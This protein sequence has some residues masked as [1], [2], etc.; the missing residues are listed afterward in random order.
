N[1]SFP[2]AF[3]SSV[4]IA[5]SATAISLVVGSLAAW[6]LTRNAF[7]AVPWIEAFLLSPLLLARIIYGVAMLIVLSQLG[8]IR[9][10]LGL[11]LA[12]A[13]IVIPY[14]VRIVGST[15]VGIESSLEEA[16]AV[17]GAN[18]I[19]TFLKVTLPLLTPGIVAATVFGFI[20]SFDEF[21]MSVFL[22]GPRTKTLPVEMFKYAELVV[23]PSVAAASVMLILGTLI[24][25]FVLERTAG[26]EKVLKA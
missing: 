17:L 15:L 8:L 18:Q 3:L 16:S 24:G 19:R 9:T 10:T 26:L 14:V 6:A 25:V 2:E 21:T 5:V 7:R 20:T 4:V 23:D 13:T 11:I 12:H 1:T 22:V